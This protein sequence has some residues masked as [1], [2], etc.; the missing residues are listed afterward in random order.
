M[1]ITLTSARVSADQEHG[2]IIRNFQAGEALT[3][4][5]AVY[6]TTAETVKKAQSD[7]TQAEA[8][9]R[10]IVVAAPNMYGETSIASGER[11]SVCVFGPLY[12]YSGMTAGT[13][14]W[15]A[16]TAGSLQQTAPSGYAHV[17]GY[18]A[19]DDVLFVDPQVTDPASS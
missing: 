17:I 4:G 13:R 19:E 11:C 12:G 1:S 3:V 9:A 18:A 16:A 7:G 2:A 6:V 8:M 15:V 14:V 10:G 5:Q